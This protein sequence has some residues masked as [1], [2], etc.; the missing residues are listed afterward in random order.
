MNLSTAQS[1]ALAHL[2]NIA[3]P[4]FLGHLTDPSKTAV[5]ASDHD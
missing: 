1:V 4:V 3:A 2:K 5:K